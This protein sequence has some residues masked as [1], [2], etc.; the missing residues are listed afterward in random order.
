MT[1]QHRHNIVEVG[2]CKLNSA[3]WQIGYKFKIIL[4]SVL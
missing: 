4:S 2:S 3:T 1:L